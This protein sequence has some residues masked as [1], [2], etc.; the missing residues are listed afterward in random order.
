MKRKRKPKKQGVFP[1]KEYL[2]V[3]LA[4]GR[5][6]FNI[7]SDSQEG[8]DFLFSLAVGYTIQY[9]KHQGKINSLESEDIRD[10]V[11][12]VSAV[13]K[14]ETATGKWVASILSTPNFDL[15]ERIHISFRQLIAGNA[16]IVPHIDKPTKQPWMKVTLGQPHRIPLN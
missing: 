1:F 16:F 5:A 13:A 9:N 11:E 10:T 3:S 6:L 12:R 4:E 7:E 14:L 2:R 8:R 15:R